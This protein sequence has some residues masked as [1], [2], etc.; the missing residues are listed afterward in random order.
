MAYFMRF[1]QIVLFLVVTDCINHILI[2]TWGLL[3]MGI[4]FGTNQIGSSSM[5]IKKF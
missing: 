2:L 5:L 1:A 3:E 4:Q